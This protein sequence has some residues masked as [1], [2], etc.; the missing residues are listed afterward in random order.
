MFRRST[1]SLV[2]AILLGLTASGP[3]LA[4]DVEQ[5]PGEEAVVLGGRVEVPSAGYALTVPEDWVAFYPSAEDAAA[6]TDA[7][8]GIDP[9]LATTLETALAEGV[10]FSFLAF[11]AGDEETGFR[12]NCNVIDYPTEG[13][14]LDLALATDAAALANMSEALVGDPV[15]TMIELPAGESARLDYALEYPGVQAVFSAYYFTDGPMF[16]LMTCT[17]TER[18]DDGWLSIAETFEFLPAEEPS[19]PGA[20]ATPSP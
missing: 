20:E 11:G 16:H 18:P 4:Q 9:D 10:G 14:S 6:I 3:M 13:A 5:E 17:G 8:R 7:L 12:D 2:A 1:V 15:T 19:T